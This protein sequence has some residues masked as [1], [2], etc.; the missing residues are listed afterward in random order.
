MSSSNVNRL[1][2]ELSA[3]L[4]EPVIAAHEYV[5]AAVVKHSDETGFRQGNSDGQNPTGKRGWLW[6]IVTPLVSYFEVLLSRSQASAQQLLGEP[7]SGV[8][9]SDHC[10]SYS[11]WHLNNDDALRFSPFSV[12]SKPCSP[13]RRWIFSTVWGRQLKASAFIHSQLFNTA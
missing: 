13:N 10:P 2:R 5:Q 11:W 7:A 8:V 6:V 12:A 3:A 4:A 1:R 9:V